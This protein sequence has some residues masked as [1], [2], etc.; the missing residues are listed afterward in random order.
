MEI[1]EYREEDERNWVE[2]R[3]LSFLDSTYYKD[4]KKE[5]EKY[6]NHSLEYLA[7][8]D[9]K[10]VGFIDVELNSDDLT[11]NK[12][13]GAIIWNL[14]VLPSYRGKG[15]ANSLWEKVK[16]ELKRKSFSYCELWTQDDKAANDFYRKVGF[17][18]KSEF[19]YLRCRPK[20]VT[21]TIR[22]SDADVNDYFAEDMLFQASYSEKE[23]LEKI[24]KDVVEVR[25]YAINL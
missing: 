17:V 4:V 21:Q 25:L 12:E 11:Q 5:K 14:G 9:G 24:C 3:L 7:I 10:V 6:P 22:L 19:T 2:C 18:Q 8:E 1:R 16:G 13:N 20:E 15:I 23:K